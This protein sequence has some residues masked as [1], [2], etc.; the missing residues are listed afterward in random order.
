MV[1]KIRLLLPT[2]SDET[3]KYTEGNFSIFIVMSS[4]E[5]WIPKPTLLAKWIYS[6]TWLKCVNLEIENSIIDMIVKII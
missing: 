5:L 6:L 2:L 4:I 3:N 1:V